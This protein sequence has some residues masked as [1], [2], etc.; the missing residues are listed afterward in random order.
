MPNKKSYIMSDEDENKDETGNVAIN[1][2]IAGGNIVLTGYNAGSNEDCTFDNRGFQLETHDTSKGII[3]C[4][5]CFSDT[6]RYSGCIS[7]LVECFGV[8]QLTG[9]FDNHQQNCSEFK[10]D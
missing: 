4:T 6:R 1:G 2:N 9:H 3:N 8:F 10:V 7:G 5:L